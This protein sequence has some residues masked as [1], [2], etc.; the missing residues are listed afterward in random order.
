MTFLIILQKYK[1][2]FRFKDTNFSISMS[3][4]IW[5][6][7]VSLNAHIHKVCHSVGISTH[8]INN[9]KKNSA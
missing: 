7:R 8:L 9:K 4:E 5:I 6:K 3:F 2:D 1:L